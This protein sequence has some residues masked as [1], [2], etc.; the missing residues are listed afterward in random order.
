ML[1]S[2]DSSLVHTFRAS[3]SI[4]YQHQIGQSHVMMMVPQSGKVA[5][6]RW[7]PPT[8]GSHSGFKL[9][10]GNL[11][12]FCIS[13]KY[14]AQYVMEPV[15]ITV[16]HIARWFRSLNLEQRSGTSSSVRPGLRCCSNENIEE[17]Q[18]QLKIISILTFLMHLCW[19]NHHHH[20]HNHH[21]HYHH[22][23]LSDQLCETSPLEQL[24]RS[25]CLR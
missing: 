6:V 17:G 25:S 4:S 23:I 19:P 14:K 5:T 21:H 1:W 12:A 20:H 7:N 8:V 13:V 11:A 9:K 22:F 10:V 16:S 3:L 2:T 18:K 15:N 24:M